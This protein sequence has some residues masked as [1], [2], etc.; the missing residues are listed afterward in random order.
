MAISLMAELQDVEGRFQPE[1]MFL[2]TKY[3]SFRADSRLGKDAL[4]FKTLRS[5][6][7]IPSMAFVV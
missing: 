4:V 5:C 2:M 3:I 1:E 7:F 6:L